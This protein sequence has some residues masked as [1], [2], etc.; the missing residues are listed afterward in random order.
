MAIR[1][2]VAVLG[3]AS[4]ASDGPHDVARRGGRRQRP[5][6]NRCS[7]F[8]SGCR[9]V[10]LSLLRFELERLIRIALVQSL[11]HLHLCVLLLGHR[12]RIGWAVGG[13][14][15]CGRSGG[16][17]G[18]VRFDEGE[19][20][21]ASVS[22][23]AGKCKASNL[24]GAFGRQLLAA[25]E[26]AAS[27]RR[28]AAAVAHPSAPHAQEEGATGQTNATPAP[29]PSPPLSSV[30]QRYRSAPNRLMEDKRKK[31]KETKT[32]ILRKRP[33][34][35]G[36]NIPPNSV[37]LLNASVNLFDRCPVPISVMD[38]RAETSA[39]TVNRLFTVVAVSNSQQPSWLAVAAAG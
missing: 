29:H 4:T 33:Q 7:L 36:S 14:G 2:S 31:K 18:S 8:V 21:R 3:S 27:A 5:A 1:M 28:E 22:T 9:T 39:E 24:R 38:S 26:G 6:P 35:N 37:T 11:D 30:D 16:G 13:G 23:R 32:K 10:D 15:G 19:R 17:R 34:K 25:T 20:G 12:D